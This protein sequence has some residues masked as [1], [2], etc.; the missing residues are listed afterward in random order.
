MSK[1]S[2]YEVSDAERQKLDEIAELA[3]PALKDAVGIFM[4]E[5]KEAEFEDKVAGAAVAY[6][7]VNTAFM[8][9]LGASKVP[10]E[11]ITSEATEEVAAAIQGMLAV[12][13]GKFIKE[14]YR[15]HH[16]RQ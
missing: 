7:L 13:V 6:L 5:C 16:E 2:V 10:K 1:T 14:L 4:E 3:L 8:V 15:K 11:K 9:M 12:E